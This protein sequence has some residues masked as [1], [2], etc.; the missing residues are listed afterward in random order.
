VP[1]SKVRKFSTRGGGLGAGGS[2]IGDV[3]ADRGN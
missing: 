2:G 1:G 3:E